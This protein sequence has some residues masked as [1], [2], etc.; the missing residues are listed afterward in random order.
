MFLSGLHCS[1]I[2]DLAFAGETI[3]HSRTRREAFERQPWRKI[4]CTGQGRRTALRSISRPLGK[5]MIVENSGG[6]RSG[7]SMWK[8]AARRHPMRR[9]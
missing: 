4:W 5:A 9:H 1:H 3:R 8:M 7:I 6:E 2:H